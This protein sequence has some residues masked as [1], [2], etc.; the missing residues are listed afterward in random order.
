MSESIRKILF[1]RVPDA[2]EAFA[3]AVMANL[4]TAGVEY[5]SLD[6]SEDQYDT[7]LDRLEPGILP[8]VLKAPR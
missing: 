1:L 7:I 8:V 4:P 6:V 5:E 3:A 2:D